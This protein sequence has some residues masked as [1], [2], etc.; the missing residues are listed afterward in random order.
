MTSQIANHFASVG[1]V[2]LEIGYPQ[3]TPGNT[4]KVQLPAIK[5]EISI[6]FT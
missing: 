1:L 2:D 4:N 6:N 3:P 5:G